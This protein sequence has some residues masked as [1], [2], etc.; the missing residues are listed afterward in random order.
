MVNLVDGA[1]DALVVSLSQGLDNQAGN[2][3]VG[4]LQLGTVTSP[5]SSP[6][7]GLVQDVTSGSGGLMHGVL[8]GSQGGGDGLAGSVGHQLSDEVAID[9]LNLEGGAFNTLERLGTVSQLDNDGGLRHLLELHCSG[10]VEG[11]FHRALT[12]H[13]FVAVWHSNLLHSVVA[14]L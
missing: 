3:C 5:Q 11:H 13:D 12:L 8:A 2:L 4:K 14:G 9:G 6:L 7:I 10:V 1:S